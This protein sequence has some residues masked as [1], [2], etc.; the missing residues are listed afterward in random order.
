MNNLK[1][2]RGGSGGG[3]TVFVALVVVAMECFE[4]GGIQWEDL[5]NLMGWVEKIIF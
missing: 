5:A 2:N 3:A 1:E 4:R